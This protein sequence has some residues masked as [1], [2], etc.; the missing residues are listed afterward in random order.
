MQRLSMMHKAGLRSAD[1]KAGGVL[2]IGFGFDV[3]VFLRGSRLMGVFGEWQPLYAEAGLVTFPVDIDRKAPAVGNYLKAGHRASAEWATK[4]ADASALGIACGKK[5][6]LTVLDIDEPCENLLA[7]AMAMFGPSPVLARTASG[8]FHAYY[9]HS[10]EGRKIRNVIEGRNVDVLGA[11]MAIAP[12]SEGAKGRYE[13]IQGSLADFGNLPVMQGLVPEPVAI[14]P[15]GEVITENGKRNDTLF[16]LCL[17][18]A[19]SV[20]DGDALR[21]FALSINTSGAWE[22]LPFDEVL[23]TASGA[24]GKQANGTNWVGSEPKVIL[25]A[26]EIDRLFLPA[27]GVVS[28]S[29][30]DAMVLLTLLRRLHFGKPSFFCAN[31]FRRRF[32]WSLPKFQLARKFLIDSGCLSMVRH[33][34]RDNGAALYRFP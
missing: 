12:P 2:S 15:G 14:S 30:Q 26:S 3:P 5:N 7:D 9:R 10:G 27:D 19:R 18:E 28:G 21:A 11:G 8:K 6:R 16:K 4:F 13:F 23:R 20:P 33:A 1:A 24:W 22:P 34:S 31:E 32:G 29:A 25:Q 17:R